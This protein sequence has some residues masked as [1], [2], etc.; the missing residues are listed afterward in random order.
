M[1]WN[2]LLQ[3]AISSIPKLIKPTNTVPIKEEIPIEKFMQ[4]VE[5]DWLNDEDTDKLY[6]EL[7]KQGKEVIGYKEIQDEYLKTKLNT[8]QQ[9]AEKRIENKRSLLSK[10]WQVW[11]NIAWS[12]WSWIMKGWAWLGKVWLDIIGWWIWLIDKETGETFWKAADEAYASTIKDIEWWQ[13][14]IWVDPE[15]TSSKIAEFGAQ[16]AATWNVW[17]SNLVKA[18]KMTSLWAKA[19]QTALW[20]G[21]M[22]AAWEAMATWEVTPLWVWTSVA[23]WWAFPVLWK[24]GG[25]LLKEWLSKASWLAPET[26]MTFF[27][28]PEVIKMIDETWTSFDSKV[29]EIQK[30]RAWYKAEQQW[31]WKAYEWI[32]DTPVVLTNLTEYI[33]PVIRDA[34]IVWNK[35]KFWPTTK[36]NLPQQKAITNAYNIVD[37]VANQWQIT[38]KDAMDVRQRLDDLINWEW[39]SLKASSVD[40]SAESTIKNI[41]WAFDEFVWV[42]VPQLKAIDAKY[43]AKIDDI[44]EITKDWFK[45]DGSLQENAFS[46]IQ[47]LFS[48]T[49]KMRLDRLETHI[50]WI[51]E[52]LRWLTALKDVDLAM[53]NKIWAYTRA[54]L[55]AW[56]IWWAWS[57]TWQDKTSSVMLWVMFAAL[58][59]PKT[60]PILL[61]NSWVLASK[62][63]PIVNKVKQ[64]IWLTPEEN[65]IVSTAVKQNFDTKVFW[66]SE[67]YKKIT[68]EIETMGKR[69]DV[70]SDITNKIKQLWEL[71]SISKTKE[72]LK[73][74]T[75]IWEARYENQYWWKSRFIINVEKDWKRMTIPADNIDWKSIPESTKLSKQTNQENI[76]DFDSLLT[77][78]ENTTSIPKLNNS[79]ST[80]VAIKY[81]EDELWF[82]LDNIDEIADMELIKKALNPLTKNPDKIL[83]QLKAKYSWNNM[84]QAEAFKWPIK[85]TTS[86]NVI[87]TPE[88]KKFMMWWEVKGIDK[89]LLEEAKKYK[90]AEEFRDVYTSKSLMDLSNPG[91]QRFWRLLEDW[92]NE[93]TWKYMNAKYTADIYWKRWNNEYKW[94]KD[95]NVP[96]VNS[97]NDIVTIYRSTSKKQ[98]DMLPWDFVS[99]SKEYAKM[100]NEDWH[101]LTLK[102]PA[103]D[104]VFQWNDFNEWI[105]SPEKLRWKEYTWWLKKIREQANSK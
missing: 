34:E 16:S 77:N 19:W 51:S 39:K 49:N 20:F 10:I 27:K 4:V 21:K 32:K 93:D 45:S 44:K 69:K 82:T 63:T 54:F 88:N 29:K 66:P 72:S 80:N 92:I 102:V 57:T 86:S 7:R 15:A 94:Q 24:L 84:L 38:V 23:L 95:S 98:K 13:R 71:S 73:G 50:P 42:Q 43:S 1:L 68:Q 101:I 26:I 30:L 53:W 103:K 89:G 85:K 90:S 83:A 78:T 28:K 18:W 8:R 40:K 104:V 2:I 47:N 74:M 33:K 22:W 3:Q 11:Q 65:K 48:P 55:W 67:R 46:K 37:N 31:I 81:I 17:L 105:Y 52:E 6:N 87:K 100:H 59:N 56:A 41:R 36:Y 35:V 99:F 61:K 70:I 14:A 79:K 76:D 91:K 60:L 97:E 12:I 96:D 62:I 64:G 9:V 25:Y 5:E 58:T 75:R